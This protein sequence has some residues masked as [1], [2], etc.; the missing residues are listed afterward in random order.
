M[1][2][3]VILV[4]DVFLRG[5]VQGGERG[6][7]RFLGVGLARAGHELFHGFNRLAD[8]VQS[9]EVGHP[10]LEVLLGGLDSGFSIG[11]VIRESKNLRI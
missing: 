3:G 2:V 8:G 5:F 11:H 1:P 4:D 9:F 6:G 7:Q 10:A